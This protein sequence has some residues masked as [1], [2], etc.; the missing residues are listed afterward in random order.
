M[1][2]REFITLLG[3]A[4]AA[5]PLAA[6]AQQGERMRRIGVLMLGADDPEAQAR[7]AASSRACRNWAGPIG[8]NVHIDYRW[9]AGKCRHARNIAAELVALAP[10][11]ILAARR[12]QSLAALQQ[13]TRTVPVVF[14]QRHRPGRRRLCRQPGAARRQRHRIHSIRIRDE[15]EWLELL[16]QIAPSVTRA[17]VL[18]DPTVR[19]HRPVRRNPVR[20]AIFR[21]GGEPDRCARRRRNRAR[22]RGFRARGRTAA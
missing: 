4:A 9:G 2:R 1:K 20:R 8:R 21:R 13:A 17:A 7:N 14:V 16:K 10:D 22:R 18:R 5:W 11:V 3:G 6:R 12:H 15:R 19:W